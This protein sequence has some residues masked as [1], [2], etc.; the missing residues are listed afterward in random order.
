MDGLIHI[1]NILDYTYNF[2]LGTRRV[3]GWRT[4]NGAIPGTGAHLLCIGGWRTLPRGTGLNPC[5]IKTR[6]GA[7]LFE[8]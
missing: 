4:L 6:G 5:T 8:V 2:S 3:G 1:D 7:E